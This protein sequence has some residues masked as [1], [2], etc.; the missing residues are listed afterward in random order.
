MEI[1]EYADWS[2]GSDGAQR[3]RGELDI[4]PRSAARQFGQL[5]IPIYTVGFGGTGV[6]GA[7]VRPYRA[8]LAARKVA[9]RK[10]V[11]PVGASSAMKNIAIF[12]MKLRL[13]AACGCL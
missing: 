6:T 13:P 1:Q 10:I 11:S 8:G 5:Q 7:S 12:L 9:L 3:A 4:D 2:L